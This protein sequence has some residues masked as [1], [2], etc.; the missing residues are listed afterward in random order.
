MGNKILQ[1]LVLSISAL[2]LS[3]AAYAAT[4]NQPPAA[5]AWVASWN[6][7]QNYGNATYLQCGYVGTDRA[8][9]FIRWDLSSIPRGSTINSG[10]M[11]LYVYDCGTGQNYPYSCDM[12]QDTWDERTITWNTQPRAGIMTVHNNAPPNTGYWIVFPAAWYVNVWVAGTFP[13]HGLRI[14]MLTAGTNRYF[15]ARSREYYDAQYRPRLIVDY[16]LP[17]P[18]GPN[19]LGRV[20]AIFR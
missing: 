8:H 9:I 4:Y 10:E 16:T 2:C 20:K 12:V 14:S 6:A 17:N 15:N 3:A 19:S 7:N 11:W 13:N 5:D 1:K 18:V